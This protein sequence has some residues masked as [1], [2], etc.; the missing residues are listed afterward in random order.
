MDSLA[1]GSERFYSAAVPGGQHFR[2]DREGDLLGTPASEIE[3]D[4]RV[5]AGLFAVGE[6]LF[7]HAL[8]APGVGRAAAQGTDVA[9]PGAQR[10]SQRGNVDLEVVGQG[11]EVRVGIQEILRLYSKGRTGADVQ[12]LPSASLMEKGI[13]W[14]SQEPRREPL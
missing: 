6:A 5:E 3:A 12:I 2:E 8:D 1:S 4:G 7:A 10:A 14:G 11:D 13:G 9:G